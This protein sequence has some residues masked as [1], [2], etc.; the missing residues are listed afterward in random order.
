[1]NKKILKW[2][3]RLKKLYL[4]GVKKEYKVWR[5]FFFFLLNKKY[6][7][8][9]KKKYTVKSQTLQ[10]GCQKMT[11]VM[12]PDPIP[13]VVLEYVFDKVNR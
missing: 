1:M 9:N 12:A 4:N 8:G 6:F 3:K 13:R 11:C 10:R 2:D 7:I 5:F